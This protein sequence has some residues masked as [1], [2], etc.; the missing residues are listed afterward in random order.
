MKFASTAQLKA[1][2][3]KLLHYVAKGHP[4]VVTRHGNVCAV[5]EPITEQDIEEL[6][7]QYGSEVRQM[8]KESAG[9]IRKN[10]YV[11][12]KQFTSGQRSYRR[13]TS[14]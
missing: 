14:R 12:L 3:N 5:L 8:A 7:F 10:R 4:V 13:S 2:A 9:D 6:A 11:T 1:G